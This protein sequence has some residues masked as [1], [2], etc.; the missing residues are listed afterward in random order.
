[1][2]LTRHVYT[3]ATP[4]MQPLV[5]GSEGKKLIE[6]CLTDGLDLGHVEHE[7]TGKHGDILESAAQNING[8][9]HFQGFE[10]DQSYYS[11]HKHT[12]DQDQ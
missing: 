11:Q 2:V 4:K 3:F 7:V 1:M 6:S 12:F 9:S 10:H 8:P 5:T